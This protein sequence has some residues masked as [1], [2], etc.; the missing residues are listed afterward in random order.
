[1]HCVVRRQGW[2]RLAETLASGRG[3]SHAVH[4]SVPCCR[5]SSHTPA[6]QQHAAALAV[7]KACAHIHIAFLAL[8]RCCTELAQPCSTRRHSGPTP[9]D[10]LPQPLP[11]ILDHAGFLQCRTS[12]HRQMR[13]M[14]LSSRRDWPGVVCTKPSCALSLFEANGV[15]APP[16][17]T[18]STVWCT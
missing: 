16:A 2:D 6:C 5:T 13:G 14:L 10:I 7:G 3:L 18:V 12:K 17:Y 8:G 4:P 15:P 9:T 1:M 11:L